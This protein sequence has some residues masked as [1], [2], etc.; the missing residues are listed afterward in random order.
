MTNYELED[1]R[2]AWLLER[3][4]DPTMKYDPDGSDADDE[5]DAIIAEVKA[6][7]RAEIAAEIREHR[8]GISTN[9]EAGL[10]RGATIAEGRKP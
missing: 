7:L 3:L 6:Q 1:L 9:Y 5:F 2:R 8:V 4:K 10:E